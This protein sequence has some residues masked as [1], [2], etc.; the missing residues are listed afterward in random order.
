MIWT[1]KLQHCGNSPDR[2]AIVEPSLYPSSYSQLLRCMFYFAIVTYP[3]F[4]SLQ[5]DYFDDQYLFVLVKKKIVQFLCDVSPQLE[6]FVIM[7][8]TMWKS[9]TI[10]LH[11]NFAVNQYH[12]RVLFNRIHTVCISSH[13]LLR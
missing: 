4:A 8:Y 1:G 10:F 7:C 9:T 2:P 13:Y 12:A 3:N 11:I 5:L 6:T